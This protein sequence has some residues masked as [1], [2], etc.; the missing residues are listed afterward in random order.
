MFL[1]HPIHFL[2]FLVKSEPQHSYKKGSYKTRVYTKLQNNT[3]TARLVRIESL[4][5][6]LLLKIFLKLQI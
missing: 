3:Q 6:L 4:D 2:K 1:F 5:G